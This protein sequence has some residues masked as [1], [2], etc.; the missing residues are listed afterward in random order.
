[1]VYRG[2]REYYVALPSK[3]LERLQA[4]AKEIAQSGERPDASPLEIARR[5]EHRLKN[6]G[7]F[8]YTLDMS[9]TDPTIDVVEDF[10]FNRKQGHCEYFA[11]ALALMLRSIDIPARLV[12]GFKGGDLNEGTGYFV[13]QQRH[14]HVWVEAYINRNWVILDGTPA[15]REESVNSLAPKKNLWRTVADFF[16]GIWSH[17]VLGMNMVE[18]DTNVYTPIKEWASE[19]LESLDEE[20]EDIK[21]NGFNFVRLMSSPILG[22]IVVGLTL[23]CLLWLMIKRRSL[24]L[25]QPP[26]AFGIWS[27]FHRLFR[28]VLPQE[29]TVRRG[30]DWRARLSQFWA[31]LMARLRG[32]ATPQQMRVEFY[33]RFLRLLK[34]GGHEPLPSQTAAEFLDTL[35]SHGQLS[36]IA[37]EVASVPPTIVAE[38]YRVR[39]GGKSLSV[40]E[41]R[42]LNRQLDQ[43]EEQWKAIAR[44]QQSSMPKRYRISSN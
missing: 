8:G 11:S 4:F 26:G 1:L 33:E 18:Q 35:Q 34:S 10:L 28:W 31:A 2:E 21:E 22:F 42:Q 27:Q 39:F 37:A 3:G 20:L 6:S 36:R 12:S 5:I 41:L 16:S 40:D 25:T 13:V 32:E 38:F 30:S 7:E 29:T 9:I 15:S 19:T 23:G 17:H 14:A 43:W 24:S 44:T